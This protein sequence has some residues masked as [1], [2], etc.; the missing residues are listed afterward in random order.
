MHRRA[1]PLALL[2]TIA[3]VAAGLA[4]AASPT[5]I[6]P[7][8]TPGVR[9]SAVTQKALFK[10]VCRKG[11]T[12][13]IRPPASYTS[14]LKRRQLL[15]FQYA[16]KNST[17]YEE[18]HLVSLELGGA[19]RSPSNLWPQPWSQARRDDNGI[20]ASL[21]RQLS[22]GVLTLRQAQAAEIVYKHKFG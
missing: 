10:T 3:L 8:H 14:A 21:H 9:Y 2:A 4:L 6:L 20:E 19:P 15:L 11:W 22:D 16:D 13:T 18:D 7:T 5:L 1:L 17:H 12:A